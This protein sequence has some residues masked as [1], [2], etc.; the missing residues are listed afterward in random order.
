MKG[1]KVN[2]DNIEKSVKDELKDVSENLHN[3]ASKAKESFNQNRGNFKKT[4]ATA[5]NGLEEI[6][7]FTLKFGGNVF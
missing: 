5:A 7:R 1:E 3:Y 4:G 6:L 2:I